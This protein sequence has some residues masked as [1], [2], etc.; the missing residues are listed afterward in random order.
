MWTCPKCKRS[1]KMKDQSHYC[2]KPTT[3]DQ[4]IETQPKEIQTIL[5]KLKEEI[6]S[7]LPQATEK[8]SWSMPTFWDRTNIIHFAAHKN[9]LGIYPGDKAIEHFEERLTEYKHSKGAIQF[10][11]DRPI[12]YELIK[13][14]ALWCY[15]TGN[16][17]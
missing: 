4:Y 17:H 15:T 14:I 11:Y 5:T 7:V 16:H 2:D 10:M 13:E 3:I 8:V 1:F 12:P 9:H 6:R